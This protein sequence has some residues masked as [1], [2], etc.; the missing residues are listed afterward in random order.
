MS[1]NSLGPFS[2][3]TLH[4]PSDRGAPPD[5]VAM[6][7]EIS[8]RAGV[9]GSAV[10]RMGVKGNPFQMRSGV[11][12]LTF[13]AANDLFAQYKDAC[14]TELMTLIWGGVNYQAYG[15]QYIP[16]RVEPIR[17]RKIGAAAG[18]LYGSTGTAWLEVLWSLL[19]MRVGG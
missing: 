9:D 16:L 5:I 3:V 4:V 17:I 12:V 2:F 14:N 1:T 19:P 15:M 11:D 7:G 10:T 13:A 18:G 8:Q 6:E